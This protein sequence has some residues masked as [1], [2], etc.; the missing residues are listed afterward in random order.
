MRRSAS[1]L[2]REPSSE[3]WPEP[4]L[5]REKLEVHRARGCRLRPARIARPMATKRATE[6]SARRRRPCPRGSHC[7][8]QER[9]QEHANGPRLGPPDREFGRRHAGGHGRGAPVSHLAGRHR[10]GGR[11]PRP[12][13]RQRCGTLGDLKGGAAPP[14]QPRGYT[15]G[16]LACLYQSCRFPRD[17][18][19]RVT[20]KAR[21]VESPQRR[22]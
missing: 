12:V 16:M 5:P 18:H 21:A 9:R 10:E 1:A 7:L 11:R 8:P 22:A 17:L 6:T 14:R 3:T 15:V 13:P 19:D 4:L 2:G 20:G